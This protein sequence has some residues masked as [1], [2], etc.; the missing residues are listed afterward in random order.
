MEYTKAI[1]T[2]FRAA[3]KKTVCFA[4][5]AFGA[6]GLNGQTAVR[7]P[8]QSSV[9]NQSLSQDVTRPFG[10][11]RY[12]P[13]SGLYK[14]VTWGDRVD[15]LKDGIRNV[16]GFL[17]NI[18]LR[19]GWSQSY[20]N[21]VTSTVMG[22]V[23]PFSLPGLGIGWGNRYVDN[24][25]GYFQLRAGPILLDNF[26]VGYGAI[27]DDIQGNFPGRSSYG[28]D[29]RW[30][31][32]VNLT[33]RLSMMF[34]DSIG[35]SI[36]PYLY[37]LPDK[38]QVGWGVPGP[39]GGF[40]GYQPNAM[41]LAQI[42]W[43]RQVGN[44]NFSLYDIFN[45][46]IYQ[47]NLWDI[48]LTSQQNFGNL[49]PIERVGRY[50]LGYGAGDLTN[51]NPQFRAGLQPSRWDGLAGYYNVVGARAVGTLGPD[52]KTL[53]FFYKT[54][55]WNKNFQSANGMNTI[56]GGAYIQKGDPNFATYAGYNFG[57]ADPYTSFIHWAVAGVNK[58]VTPGMLVFVQGGY[59]WNTGVNGGTSGELVSAGFQ[60]M[61]GQRTSHYFEIGR[62]VYTPVTGPYSV[63]NYVDY[64]ISHFLGVRSN[65][66]A[67]AGMSDNR[68][69][70]IGPSL[71][72][73]Y[74]GLIFNTNVTQ[75]L[76][77][78]ASSGWSKTSIGSNSFISDVWTHRFGLRHNL[79]QNIQSQAYYQYQETRYNTSAYNNSEHFIYLGVTKRF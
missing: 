47:Y 31:Q 50:S 66:S 7:N 8:V 35:V 44:W 5:I 59:Y 75:R 38:G 39:L 29:D 37:W 32:I 33:F 3:A 12:M 1:L 2:G 55:Y 23:G 40:M 6:S 19:T 71:S 63:G 25:N 43:N 76:S 79:T 65:I 45:P 58:R 69:V 21:G 77:M 54:D 16:G 34:G 46:R 64:R 51:Y 14:D 26:Y 68:S 56:A 42:A 53:L 78:F 48:L 18:N 28:A 9:G 24:P 49:S 36:Q 13:Q 30:G 10:E 27:Y 4:V 61:L 22:G 41:A 52:V 73:K 70:T 60:Q 57:S 74:A 11:Y 15:D 62:R 67:Y 20:S 72:Y 17:N